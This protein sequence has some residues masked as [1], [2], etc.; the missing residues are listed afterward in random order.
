MSNDGGV[1]RTPVLIVGGGPVGFALALELGYRGQKSML[2]ERDAGT[3]LVMLAKAGGIN[4]RSLEF[5]RRWGVSEQMRNCGIPVDHSRDTIHLTTIKGHFI[6]RDP[7]PSLTEQWNPRGSPEKFCKLPQYLF[8]PLLAKAVIERGATQVC[9]EHEFMDLEQHDDRVVSR[10]RNIKTGEVIIIESDY[11]VG[12]D[13]AASKVRQGVDIPFEGPTLGY[14]VSA[15]LK[16]EK[17][18]QYHP[19]GKVERFM[20]IDT[21]GTWANMT[22]VDL[23]DLWRFTLIGTH[24]KLDLERLDVAG[25]V[26]RA[27]GEDIPFELERVMP[28]RRSECTATQF[29]KGRVF[30]AGDAAHTTSPTGGHGLNT[31]LGD[32]AGLGW[33]LDARLRGWGGDALL[34]SYE[35]ERRVVA[36]RNSSNSTRNYKYWVGGYDFSEVLKE[37]PFGDE[38]RRGLG[39]HLGRVLRSEWSSLGVELGYRYDHSPVIV[40][41]GSPA[42][43]DEPDVYV[44]T[45]RPGHRAPHAWLPDGRSTIDLFGKGFVLL[46]FGGVDCSVDALVAAADT[47]GVPLEVIDIDSPEIAEL[48]ERRLALVRPDGHVCWRGDRLPGDADGLIDTVTGRHPLHQSE[49]NEATTQ[50]LAN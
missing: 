23:M 41:D 36:M 19:Y 29:R 50:I 45:A 49:R 24:E 6:G 43:P 4:P 3:G 34:D 20:F 15:M 30:L 47:R 13:G 39:E 31:S 14:S 32:V 28:W 2:I 40:P 17:F 26:K 38:A 33:V 10:A 25:V 35:T 7:M 21:N 9:Y 12:C 18:E 8:D 1:F 44:Q 16:I 37:G 48:Y 42:T 11:V 27:L 5:C 22:S 46:R